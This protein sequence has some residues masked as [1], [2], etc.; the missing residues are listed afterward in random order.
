MF[1]AGPPGSVVFRKGEVVV[2]YGGDQCS[3]KTMNERY[4]EFT[5]PYGF[6]GGGKKGSKTNYDGACN[7][8]LGT[9]VNHKP[10]LKAN[11]VL[12]DY[13]GW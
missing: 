3:E 5:A 8:G 10:D 2:Y 7:R 1:A 11:P 4:G 9:L 6:E 12:N 13:C